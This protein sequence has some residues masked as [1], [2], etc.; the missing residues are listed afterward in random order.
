MPRASG[1][2][3]SSRDSQLQGQ[4]MQ[5]SSSSS[6]DADTA[7][8]FTSSAAS[9]R[10]EQF[11]GEGGQGSVVEGQSS[12]GSGQFSS[13]QGQRAEEAGQYS[14][15][16]SKHAGQ[17]GSGIGRYESR[18]EQPAPPLHLRDS[19]QGLLNPKEDSMQARRLMF[20][21]ELDMV[22][23]A[24]VRG[25]GGGG[26][27][28]AISTLYLLGT[29]AASHIPCFPVAKY[30]LVVTHRHAVQCLGALYTFAASHD[31]H[32]DFTWQS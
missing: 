27:L 22:H 8:R 6:S 4:M 11:A 3:Q 12:L 24:G 16:A 2:S 25:W 26:V 19:I 28:E 1:S 13:K 23:D 20:L 21:S 17:S 29:P 7:G 18:P 14:N 15:R 5:G 31:V 30:L 9:Q 32:V 10:A